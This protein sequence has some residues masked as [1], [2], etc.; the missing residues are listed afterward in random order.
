V[1]QDPADVVEDFGFEHSLD[2]DGMQQVRRTPAHTMPPR[3]PHAPPP[4]LRG[5]CAELHELAWSV[6]LNCVRC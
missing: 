1:G 6:L 5:A 2:A 3:P 4:F